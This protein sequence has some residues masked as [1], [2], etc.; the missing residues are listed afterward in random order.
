M[1]TTIIQNLVSNGIKFSHRGGSIL[2]TAVKGNDE[3]VLI[4]S[5]QGVGIKESDLPG[6]FEQHGNLQTSGTEREKGSGLGLV[7]CREFA[8]RHGGSIDVISH[9]G[10]GSRFIVSFPD[11]KK[12]K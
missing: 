11:A 1:L 8:K 4:V 7:L 6:L 9:P 2:V 5:D 10:E 12:E 3:L